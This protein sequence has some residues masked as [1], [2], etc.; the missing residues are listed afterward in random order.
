[1]CDVVGVLV[2]V[3]PGD[4]VMAIQVLVAFTRVMVDFRYH[5]AQELGK[6]HSLTYTTAT[7]KLESFELHNL[8]HIPRISTH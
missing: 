1:M 7:E 6:M 5:N 2:A 3:C 8:S 4:A